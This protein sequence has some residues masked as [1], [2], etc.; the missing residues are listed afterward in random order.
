MKLKLI[1]FASAILSVIGVLL[2]GIG[3]YIE[4][5]YIISIGQTFWIIFAYIKGYK[6]LL[7]QNVI[8][9]LLNLFAAY[10]WTIKGLG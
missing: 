3:P 10:N 2:I 8:L 7:L 1:E 6:Y 9:I 5:F 4:G